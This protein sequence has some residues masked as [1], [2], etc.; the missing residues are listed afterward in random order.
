MGIIDFIY[1][2]IKKH[3]NGDLPYR[4]DGESS[5]EDK[6]EYY[7]AWIH[8]F[9]VKN[10]QI[11]EHFDVETIERD[12][13]FNREY[14]QVYDMIG[15]RLVTEVECPGG[16][17]DLEKIMDEAIKIDDN[18]MHDEPTG[19]LFGSRREYNKGRNYY[20]HNHVFIYLILYKMKF[21]EIPELISRENYNALRICNDVLDY[22]LREEIKEYES[23]Y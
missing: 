5:K 17:L 9:L 1:D 4:K 2:F 20:D 13:K 3:D 19:K 11:F 16:A 12:N 15:N 22:Q 23:D 14:N 21:D 6:R 8:N 7:N 10:D 18:N